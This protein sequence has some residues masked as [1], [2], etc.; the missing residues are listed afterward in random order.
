ME[1]SVSGWQE[2]VLAERSSNRSDNRA[3]TLRRKQLRANRRKYDQIAMAEN[4]EP[5][6]HAVYAHDRL[7]ATAKYPEISN[8]GQ[9]KRKI[10]LIDRDS[11]RWDDTWKPEEQSLQRR[12]RTR[13]EFAKVRT[14]NN[15]RQ[16]R[17]D[18]HKSIQNSTL[19][20]KLRRPMSSQGEHRPF[21]TNPLKIERS[22]TI[23]SKTYL[24]TH[25]KQKTTRAPNSLRICINQLENGAMRQVLRCL[26]N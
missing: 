11:D 4:I 7:D 22:T 23:H 9:L 19:E 16:G 15:D 17:E 26:A 14:E 8:I 1:E 13:S 10:Q 20:G 6:Y 5:L 18:S 25:S 12:G 2:Q 3:K 24:K 21:H